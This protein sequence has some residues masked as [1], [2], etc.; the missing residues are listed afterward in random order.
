MLAFSAS[1]SVL[2]NLGFSDLCYCAM[3]GHDLDLLFAFIYLQMFLLTCLDFFIDFS[4]SCSKFSHLIS[5]PIVFLCNKGVLG[6][7]KLSG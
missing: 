5:C 7:N 3:T 6:L 2:R 1:S 4:C